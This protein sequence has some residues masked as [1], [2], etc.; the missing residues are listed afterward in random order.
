VLDKSIGASFQFVIRNGL[1]KT[2]MAFIIEA[3]F[4]LSLLSFSVCKLFRETWLMSNT[5]LN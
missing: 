4:A 3:G 5:F 1:V 2:K